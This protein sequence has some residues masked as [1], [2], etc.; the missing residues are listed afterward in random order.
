MR[1]DRRL[2]ALE[3]EVQR[4]KAVRIP[5]LLLRS[6][7]P[8]DPWS[9]SVYEAML[10]EQRESVRRDVLT[11]ALAAALAFRDGRGTDPYGPAEIGAT[12]VGSPRPV[13]ANSVYRALLK[14]WANPLPFVDDAFLRQ[15][16]I[17]RLV[18]ELLEHE[19]D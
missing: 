15:S 12:I 10:A 14:S 16:Q 17:A 11:Q 19:E 2:D 4:I 1:L 5:T 6:E 13:D 8:S 9:R 7:P 3:A 18:I